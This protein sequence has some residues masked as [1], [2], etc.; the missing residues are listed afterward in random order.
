M[1]T[2]SLQQTLQIL[3]LKDKEGFA[4][5]FDISVFALNQQS[6]TGG[7][8]NVYNKA[9][10]LIGKPKEKVSLSSLTIAASALL[11]ANKNPNHRMNSTRNIEL[12]NG[13]IKK[14]NIRLID[15]INGKKVEY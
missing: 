9:K 2:I 15:T 10:L 11:V 4:F 6:K 12:E 13:L 5:P 14:I 8:L 7:N 3:E 1:K